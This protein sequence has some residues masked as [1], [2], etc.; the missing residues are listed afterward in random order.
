[1]SN[2]T[3]DPLRQLPA[4]K[5]KLTT[6]TNLAEIFD[7]FFDHLSTNTAFIGMGELRPDPHLRETIARS[8]Q[9]ILKSDAIRFDQ[10]RMLYISKSKFYHGSML[11]NGNPTAFLFFEDI[12]KGAISLYH[13]AT[14]HSYNGRFTL[15]PIN[16]PPPPSP[17]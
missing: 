6:A 15:Q 12:N 14:Q 8:V 11:L 10:E 3:S 9:P 17:N 2:T 5:L 16:P 1:M 4:L 13:V 7:F